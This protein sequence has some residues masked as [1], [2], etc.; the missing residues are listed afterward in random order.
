MAKRKKL[1]VAGIKAAKAPKTGRREYLD[2]VVPQLALRVTATG[3]KSFA[4]RARVKGTGK[5]IRVTLG[6][7]P[8]VGLSEARDAAR[9]ALISAERGID[10]NEAKR[11]EAQELK[12]CQADT[13]EEVSKLF[14]ERHSKKRGNRTWR[15]TQRI[16]AKYVLPRWGDRPIS[17][18]RKTDAVALLD[19]VEDSHGMY[20]ANR[21]L[22][23]VRAL[24]NWALDERGLIE[25]TPIGR[26]MARGKEVAR[27]RVL[28][29]G[30]IKALWD[31]CDEVGYPFGPM[32]RLLLLTGQRRNEVAGMEW[33]E[34]DL[35]HA[36]WTIPGARAK[37]EKEHIVPLAPVAVSIIEA[38]PRF[39]GPHCFSTTSGHRPV[40]GFTTFKARADA[41]CGV[42]GWRIHDLRRTC[43]TGMAAEGVPEIV[44]E[45]VLNHQKKSLATV[46]NRHK[47][48]KEKRDA[49][50][51][52]AQRVMN[53]VSPPPENV[54]PIRES[55]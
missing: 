28:D 1:T 49:L 36:E 26:K 46:Y 37:N 30:E 16:F 55:A 18:I 40:S 44:S 38:L 22:D 23:A 27:D 7:F 17:E 53:I 25:S 6:G 5:Q 8:A 52:W 20:M 12:Q 45:K 51:R 9:E 10:P 47:Y 42:R 41:I 35:E 50:N 54:L 13:F 4:L 32:L 19:H 2:T 39:E 21:T 24:F 43:R 31:G 48:S 34:I 29:D 33:G 15:E 3:T 14:I 11:R